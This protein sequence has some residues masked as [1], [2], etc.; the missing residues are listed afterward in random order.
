MSIPFVAPGAGGWFDPAASAP[1]QLD[2]A[3]V[4]RL[5]RTVGDRLQREQ[6][7]LRQAGEPGLRGANEQ[8]Y[9]RM[10]TASAIREH[11]EDLLAHGEA[12]LS[13]RVELELAAAIHARMYGAGQLQRLLDDAEIEDIDINAPDEVWVTRAGGQRERVDPVA[14]DDEELIELVQTLGS[15]AGMSSRPF[16]AANPQ[17]DL[18]LPDGSRLSA[19]MGV[20]A[21]PSVSIRR[22]R[23]DK[24]TLA[25]LV[26]NDTLSEEAA[27]FLRAMV[28]ARAN[29]MIA[30]ATGAG[31]TT[32]LRALAGEIGPEERL[33]TVENA[34]ELGLRTDFERHPD[35][36]EMEARVANSEGR[37]A[38]GMAELV[39]RTLRMNPSRVIV[40]E[41]LGP[42]VVTMLNAMSQGNDGS[43][44]TIHARNA[45]EVFNRIATY[46][47]QSEERLPQEATYSLIAG[48]LD[49]V[50]YMVK[51]R[52]TGVRRLTQVLEI[53]GYDPKIGVASGEVFAADE[54]GTAVRTVSGVHRDAAL[55]AAGWC[56]PHGGWLR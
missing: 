31:K 44:S 33:V 38:I 53:T 25:D 3:L 54:T 52:A 41:V 43:L 42:E 23:Y 36:V 1:M 16:D 26:G 13:A 47:V 49:F 46:A 9:A 56:D 28:R 20:T 11:A 35:C 30:G 48:G 37:G 8:Q 51:D 27:D 34:L 17:L 40:G 10:L 5:H 12:P 7:R 18:R 29:V 39:R 15:Y 19:V 2:M 24:V 4:R 21:H 6:A 55:L 14:G 22:H 50:L 45:R 32:L